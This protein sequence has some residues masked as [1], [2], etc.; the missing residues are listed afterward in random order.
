MTEAMQDLQKRA[1]NELFEKMKGNDK[2][3]TFKAPTGSGKTYM[4]SALMDK[5]LSED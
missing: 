3:L 1:V 4:M 2:E 5:I